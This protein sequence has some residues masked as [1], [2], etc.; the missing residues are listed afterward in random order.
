MVNQL[1]SERIWHGLIYVCTMFNVEKSNIFLFS[2]F[3]D[4]ILLVINSPWEK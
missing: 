4:A 2:A 1:I 3:I